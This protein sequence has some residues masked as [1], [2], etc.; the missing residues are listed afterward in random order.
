MKYESGIMES[1]FSPYQATCRHAANIH[2]ISDDVV[3]DGHL[4]VTNSSN[5][6]PIKMPKRWLL[7]YRQHSAHN[8]KI[9]N[10]VVYS[11]V[12]TDCR[13]RGHYFEGNVVV[14]FVNIGFGFRGYNDAKSVIPHVVQA[15][16]SRVQRVLDSTFGENH[17]RKG[18]SVFCLTCPSN[19][20]R[21]Y[22]QDV[23]LNRMLY[24]QQ[25]R[26]LSFEYPYFI[27]FTPQMYVLFLF[28]SKKI[29]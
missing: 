17:R 6:C 19:L 3:N 25:G 5:I 4:F 28:K 11:Y 29:S 20:Q 12:V 23:R 24:P 27:F 1:I 15:V 21:L 2:H 26:V 14:H 8:G 22:R 13:F 10:R 7:T 9:L 16:T 18:I